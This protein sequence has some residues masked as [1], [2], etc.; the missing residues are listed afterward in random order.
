MSGLGSYSNK[1]AG[2][3]EDQPDFS[4]ASPNRGSL[5]H[6][7]GAGVGGGAHAHHMHLSGEPNDV[8]Q[9]VQRELLLLRHH[10]SPPEKG[11]AR[12]DK[13]H[14][15]GGG[16]TRGHYGASA[17]GSR[18]GSPHKPAVL[19]GS[20]LEHSQKEQKIVLQ[21]RGMGAGVL[22]QPTVPL[23]DVKSFVGNIATLISST[24]PSLSRKL[25][26]SVEMGARENG[27]AL[28]M[29]DTVVA[30]RDLCRIFCKQRIQLAQLV[31]QRSEVSRV[32]SAATEMSHDRLLSDLAA[33]RERNLALENELQQAT[34]K[35][36]ELEAELSLYAS[37]GDDAA[38]AAMAGGQGGRGGPSAPSNHPSVTLE[39]LLQAQAN[40][41]KQ[42]TE[43]LETVRRNQ[44]DIDTLK[45]GI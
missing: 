12:K 26:P 28:A 15:L 36:L 34:S 8:I 20:V 33:A 17:S 42:L 2:G 7:G 1:T 30:V 43:V 29:Q 9:S 18:G 6:E 21:P 45:S 5:H 31:S 3:R 37:G 22:G 11:K 32:L 25:G 23:E 41:S 39:T 38:A 16:E 10:L 44:V 13:G 35:Q 27:V 19:F 14:R 24:D 40:Q 4:F